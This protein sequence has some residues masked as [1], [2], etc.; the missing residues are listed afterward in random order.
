MKKIILLVICLFLYGCGNEDINYQSSDNNQKN[1][2]L[3]IN[4]EKV[5]NR[6]IKE[7]IKLSTNF[8]NINVIID[9]NKYALEEALEN[10]IITID[11]IKEKM[12]LVDTLVDCTKVYKS[13]KDFSNIE[14]YLYDCWVLHISDVLPNTCPI[15]SVTPIEGC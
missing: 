2:I 12:T 7:K 4:E 1:F 6:T 10:K 3:E 5:S 14:F 15:A 11:D 9:S 8:K 13:S